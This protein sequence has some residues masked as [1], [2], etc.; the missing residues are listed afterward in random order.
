MTSG[1]GLLTVLLSFFRGKDW[2]EA[3]STRVAAGLP[4]TWLLGISIAF[5]L[6]IPAIYTPVVVRE[7]LGVS[8]KYHVKIRTS[9]GGER[10]PTS[11]HL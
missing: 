4:L 1:V 2:L 10:G 11:G 3:R 6:F 9:I 7:Y 8:I 5:L